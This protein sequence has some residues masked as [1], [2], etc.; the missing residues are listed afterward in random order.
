MTIDYGLVRVHACITVNVFISPGVILLEK[1]LTSSPSSHTLDVSATDGAGLVSSSNARVTISVLDIGQNVPEFTQ[2]LY[3]FE[4][5]ENVDAGTPVG[6]V[7][8][9]KGSTGEGE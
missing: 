5:A 7:G 2:S 6:S 8:V 9:A 4:V 3:R 1:G